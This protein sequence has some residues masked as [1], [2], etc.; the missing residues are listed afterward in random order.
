MWSTFFLRVD[1]KFDQTLM[2]SLIKTLRFRKCDQHFLYEWIALLI[3][4]SRFRKFDQH[5]LYEWIAILITFVCFRN[6]D[7][8]FRNFE[9][10]KIFVEISNFGNFDFQKKN[11]QK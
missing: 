4:N 9:K 10:S 2:T 1:G 6:F 5:F 7:Q 11:Q 3:K 8:H